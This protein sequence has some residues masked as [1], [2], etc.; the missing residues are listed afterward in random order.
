MRLCV[1]ASEQRSVLLTAML[2]YFFAFTSLP[3]KRG[4]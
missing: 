3:R 4:D 1:S 2:E